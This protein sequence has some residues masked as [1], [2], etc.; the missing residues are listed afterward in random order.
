MHGDSAVPRTLIIVPCGQRKI[1]DRDPSRGPT[2]A[3][4][5]YIG[6]PFRLNC[7]YAERFGDAWIIL[8]ARYGFIMP[9]FPIPGP[10]DVTF[11]RRS[12]A[13]AAIE[14]LRRQV[15]ELHLYRFD[16]VVGLGGA[17]YCRA[18]EAA[19]AERPVRLSYPTAG[20]PIGKAM[21]RLK[22]A[23]MAGQPAHPSAGNELAASI[24]ISTPCR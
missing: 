21:Q 20:L 3:R 14:L 5:A 15:E 2:P 18:V 12:T 23:L 24:G 19:F 1:W 11:K 17:D 9:D 4:E 7:R 16:L 6:A 22:H 13:P 10:Y 8:S